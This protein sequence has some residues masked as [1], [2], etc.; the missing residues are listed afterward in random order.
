[1]L[2][3]SLLCLY[4]SFAYAKAVLQEMNIWTIIR[5]MCCVLKM[6]ISDRMGDRLIC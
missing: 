1:M 2:N 3:Y 6:K 5:N 4:L